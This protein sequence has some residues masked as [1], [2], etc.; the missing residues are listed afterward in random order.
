MAQKLVQIVQKT[1]D[2]LK[3]QG[4]DNIGI[5]TKSK[6]AQSTKIPPCTAANVPDSEENLQKFREAF[7]T[8][9]GKVCPI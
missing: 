1:V 8:L 7:K 2:E 6:I 9:T 3:A 5:S 4:I